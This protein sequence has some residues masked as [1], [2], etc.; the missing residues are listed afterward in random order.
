MGTVKK[1]VGAAVVMC[2]LSSGAQ[3]SDLIRK[4]CLKAGR[5]GTTHSLCRCIQQV[6]DIKLK[7]RKDQRLAAS[8]F[9]DPHKAQEIRQSDNA[10]HERFWDRYKIWGAT[11]EEVCA[12][13]DS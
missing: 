3:G 2:L 1:I 13:E 7:T 10:G 12:P 5:V 11:A 8:F 6:A 4:A 9:K